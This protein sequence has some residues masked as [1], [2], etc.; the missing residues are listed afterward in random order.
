[1]SF[2]VQGCL[3]HSKAKEIFICLRIPFLGQ[4]GPDTGVGRACSASPANMN[5]AASEQV[6]AGPGREQLKPRAFLVR[7]LVQP[8]GRAHCR[9]R[10]E[11]CQLQPRAPLL[12]GPPRRDRGPRLVPTSHCSS[13]GFKG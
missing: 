12:P 11:A 7:K 1:M 6:K 4:T 3:K 2:Y 8:R 13:P 5:T 10:L 9:G